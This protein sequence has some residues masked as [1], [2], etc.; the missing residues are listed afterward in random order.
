MCK[1]L[2]AF[3]ALGFVLQS[4]AVV[5]VCP[6]QNQPCCSFPARDKKLLSLINKGK[7]PYLLGRVVKRAAVSAALFVW[8][9][10]TQNQSQGQITEHPSGC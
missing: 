8:Q 10:I 3:I 5:W 9:R 2:L 6:M 4:P 7:H 1:I